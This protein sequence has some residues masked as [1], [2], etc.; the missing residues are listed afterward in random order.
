MCGLCNG[1]TKVDLLSTSTMEVQ[2]CSHCIQEGADDINYF[3][4]SMNLFEQRITAFEQRIT[5]FEQQQE[6]LHKRAG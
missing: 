5:A 3:N 2:L 1:R 4:I 6:I